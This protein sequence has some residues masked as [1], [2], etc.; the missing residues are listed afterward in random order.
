MKKKYAYP[1]KF[2]NEDNGTISVYFPDLQG[3]WTYDDTLEGAA[4]MAIE[5]LELWIEIALESG[6]EIPIPTRIKDVKADNGCVMLV[7][8]DVETSSMP[9]VLRSQK[10]TV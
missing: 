1:A 8:A 4:L 7:V 2:E 9:K 5:A 10:M 6:D 3:C